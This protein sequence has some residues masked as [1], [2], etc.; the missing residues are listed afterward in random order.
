MAR[1]EQCP[2]RGA[3]LCASVLLVGTGCFAGSAHAGALA[4]GPVEQVNLKSSTFVVLGQTYRLSGLSSVTPGS[5]VAVDGTESASGISSVQK[6][7]SL[8]QANVP[9]ATQLLVTGI[10]SAA[11][12]DGHIRVGKLDVDITATLT[13]DAAGVSLGQL[14]KIV[15]TQP[16]SGGTFVARTVALGIAGSGAS[17]N[18]IA[19]SGSSADGIAGSG[20][21]SDGIAGSGSSAKGIAGSGVSANGIAGSGSSADG[22]AGSGVSSDGIAGSGS[23][24]KGIAGSGVSANGIA[25][26]G[27]SADGI[28][29][30][31]SN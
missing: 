15:G 4:V 14:V 8:P 6:L 7:V 17:A 12:D 18:G 9:G 13:N 3:L 20:V 24:A 22:I 19:G 10:V 2:S 11:S 23:S 1:S 25:G 31:G 29:G 30:S 28:A 16:T 21:S 26:S 5:L 27:S